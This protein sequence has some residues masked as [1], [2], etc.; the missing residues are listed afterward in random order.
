ML[1]SIF[2]GHGA[3]SLIFEENDYVEAIKN[4]PSTI[5]KPDAIVVFSAHF[6]E[7]I[8]TISVAQN[9]D[10]IYDFYGFEDK[11]YKIKYPAKGDPKLA[12][13]IA[14]LL[15]NNGIETRFDKTRGLDHG[16]WSI[17]KLMYPKCDIPVVSMS[18]NANLTPQEQYNIGKSLIPL[19]DKNILLI[20]SGGIVHNLGRVQMDSGSGADEWATQFDNW[21]IDKIS[22]WDTKSMFEYMKLA[23][24]VSIAVPRAEHFVLLLIAMG[25][26]ALNKSPKLVKSCIQYRNL[27]LDLFSFR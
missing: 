6:E 21:I 12:K 8:Q 9:Y 10:T 4:Y 18:I 7:E 27:S 25:S 1:S 22:K 24:S 11:L 3:P 23:P 13:E 2:V 5:Q 26:G 16:A 19:K 15:N 14:S 20:M 17:L